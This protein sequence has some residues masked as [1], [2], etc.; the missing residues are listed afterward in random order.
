MS[1]RSRTPHKELVLSRKFTPAFFEEGDQR[2][3]AVKEIK[4]RYEELKDHTAADSY[5]KD[6]LVRRAVFLELQLETFEMAAV[7][8]GKLDVN[9]YTQMVNCFTGLLNKLGLERAQ[10][11]TMDLQTYIHGD[12]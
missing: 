6:T 9:I 3:A 12:R 2:M 8:T 11:K 5:Q 10:R 4:R 7:K 1:R